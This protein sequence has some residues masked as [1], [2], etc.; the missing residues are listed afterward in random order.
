SDDGDHNKVVDD[1]VVKSIEN[2]VDEEHVV[3][4]A[5]ASNVQTNLETTV[6]PESPEMAIGSDKQKDSDTITI[7]NVPKESAD[8][9]SHSHEGLKTSTENLN[10]DKSDEQNKDTDVDAIDV[11]NLTSG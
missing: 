2:T 10:V 6:V 1:P 4:D 11:D 5:A 7:G 3:K 9:C 8:V